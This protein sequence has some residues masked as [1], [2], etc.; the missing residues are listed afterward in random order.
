M[1]PRQASDGRRP[2]KPGFLMPLQARRRCE[3]ER[4]QPAAAHIETTS[5]Y[6]GA[7]E[8]HQYL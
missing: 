1:L 5:E 4:S 3:H 2:E 7:V 6:P 8:A